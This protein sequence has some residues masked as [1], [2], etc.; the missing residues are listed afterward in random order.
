MSKT[1]LAAAVAVL[2]SGGYAAA[3]AVKGEWTGF[4]TDTHCGKHGA[5]ADHTAG[6]VVKC[7]K[8]GSKAQILNDADGKIYD[9]AAFDAKVQPLVGKRVT[10]KG[11]MDSDT[12][13]ITVDEA[14]VAK[15][16]K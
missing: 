15:G 5:N 7:M 11:S 14:A 1:L 3:D 6:C 8:G 2:L 16:S 4:I 12:H 9:L 10:L 13:V